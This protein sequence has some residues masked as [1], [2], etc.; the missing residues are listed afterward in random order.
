MGAVMGAANAFGFVFLQSLHA[1]STLFGV[2]V[3]VNSAVECLFLFYSDRLL[4]RFGSRSLLALSVVSLALRLCGFPLVSLL[5]APAAL[6]VFDPLLGVAVA[7]F[8]IASVHFAHEEAPPGLAATAQAAMAS[9][10][11]GLGLGVGS[12]V[13]G[14]LYAAL[15]PLALFAALIAALAVTLGVTRDFL[16]RATPTPTPKRRDDSAVDRLV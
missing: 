4:R 16:L 15:G 12:L 13:A 9:L 3:V 10:H 2:S 5:S 7:A 8:W 6:L 14:A 11:G 1:S